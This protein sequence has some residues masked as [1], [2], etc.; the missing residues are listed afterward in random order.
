MNPALLKIL[1]NTLLSI[2]S[3]L[4]FFSKL[5]FL[6]TIQQDN[7][8]EK[9]RKWRFPLIGFLLDQWLDFWAGPGE[10][11]LTCD[12]LRGGQ[13]HLFVWLDTLLVLGFSLGHI[14]MRRQCQF[15]T[16]EAEIHMHNR[17][18]VERQTTTIDASVAAIHITFFFLSFLDLLCTKIRESC[19]RNPTRIV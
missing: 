18:G 1:E 8:K 9:E 15:K 5:P 14:R 6:V 12:K 2:M 10:R 3:C 4:L 13:L 11:R 7:M 16:I 19:R 17:T